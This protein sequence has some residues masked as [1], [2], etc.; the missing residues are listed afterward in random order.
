MDVAIGGGAVFMTLRLETRDRRVFLLQACDRINRAELVA[1]N[2]GLRVAA[3][4]DGLTGVA[5]RRR[6][7]E[8]LGETWRNAQERSEPLA[9]IIMDID[10]FKLF[11]DH[12][13]HKGGDDCLKLVAAA[14]R[15]QTRNGDLFARYGGEEFAV[16]LPGTRRD[17]VCIIAERMRLAVEGMSLKHAG[18]GDNAF[19][20]A[21]FGAAS[22]VP[23][24][25]QGSIGLIEAADSSL[26]V[27]KRGGRNRVATCDDGLA[28]NRTE[29]AD[30]EE[31]DGLASTV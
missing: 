15:R 19:V 3:H 7:D 20:T 9:L 17:E 27:A 2:H 14:A 24:P 5:N 18:L 22:M 8:V 1:R 13:G 23:A 30:S 21:S 31:S 29:M 16:I 6:F 10:H 4:T 11:N 26:Y 28:A 25:G 12:H